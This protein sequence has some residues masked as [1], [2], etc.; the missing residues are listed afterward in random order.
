MDVQEPFP[1]DSSG[2]NPDAEYKED[3]II[4]AFDRHNLLRPETVESLLILFRTTQDPKYD[5]C[6]LLFFAVF[7]KSMMLVS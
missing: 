3:I 4:H 7:I 5:I 6:D 2:G 1:E